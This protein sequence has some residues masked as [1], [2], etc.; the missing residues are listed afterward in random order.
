[1]DNDIIDMLIYNN[2]DE[3]SNRFNIPKFEADMLCQ[4][5][6]KMKVA[7]KKCAKPD[8]PENIAIKKISKC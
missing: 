3:L 8:I 5:Y 7:A 1:M 4:M 2:L 6:K